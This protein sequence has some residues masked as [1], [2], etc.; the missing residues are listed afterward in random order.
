MIY[1]RRVALVEKRFDGNKEVELMLQFIFL[2][3]VSIVGLY[4]TT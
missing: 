1:E 3:L 4:R 2:F